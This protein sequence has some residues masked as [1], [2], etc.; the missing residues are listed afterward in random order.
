MRGAK[1]HESVL[2]C[3][4][5]GVWPPRGAWARGVRGTDRARGRVLGNCCLRRDISGANEYSCLQL[6]RVAR[7]YVARRVALNRARTSVTQRHERA[8]ESRSDSR[9]LSRCCCSLSLRVLMSPSETRARRGARSLSGRVLMR[10]PFFC[11]SG[12]GRCEGCLMYTARRNKNC[13]FPAR[14]AADQL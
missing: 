4:C 9:A 10:K 3:G 8:I 11:L 13:N 2:I 14:A 12:I 6:S 7:T 5:Q 1:H